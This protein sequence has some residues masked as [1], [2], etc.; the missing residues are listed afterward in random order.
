MPLGDKHSGVQ[1]IHTARY[2]L[3]SCGFTY[4]CEL[5]SFHG[6]LSLH[7]LKGTVQFEDNL[8][9]RCNFTMELSRNF[10]PLCNGREKT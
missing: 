7:N 6:H 8:P 9:L 3:E 1:T 4:F 5:L 2:C 10:L